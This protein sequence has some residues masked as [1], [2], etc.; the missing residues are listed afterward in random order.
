[1][2]KCVHCGAEWENGPD[3]CLG[4]LPGIAHACCGHG[5]IRPAYCVGWE[6]CKPGDSCYDKRDINKSTYHP[7]GADGGHYE[8]DYETWDGRYPPK[9]GV[10][11]PPRE[12]M[13]L[14]RGKDAL[15]YMNSL[16]SS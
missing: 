6:G 15:D 13:F 5:E 3:P 11:Y 1:M 10:W 8:F 16:K 9:H 12:G 14:K 2:R 7:N 4:I